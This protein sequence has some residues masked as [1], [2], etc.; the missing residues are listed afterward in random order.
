MRD[1]DENERL[2]YCL[3]AR[4]VLVSVFSRFYFLWK[5]V[6]S[7]GGFVGLRA[8]WGVEHRQQPRNYTDEEKDEMD[9]KQSW[10]KRRQAQRPYYSTTQQTE[11]SKCTQDV[12]CMDGYNKSNSER[13]FKKK[14]KVNGNIT[15]ATLS[16][17]LLHSIFV[18]SQMPPKWKT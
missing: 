12:Y 13:F 6:M 2:L 5:P 7:S 3:N 8:G 15:S 11:Y 17:P 9:D 16:T 1:K 14:S 10:R 18:Q 4:D